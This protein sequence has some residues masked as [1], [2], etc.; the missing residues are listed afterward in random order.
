MDRIFDYCIVLFSGIVYVLLAKGF[1]KLPTDRQI[2]F[3][4]YSERK[5][6]ILLISAYALIAFSLTAIVWNL[7]FK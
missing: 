5:K 7:V 3:D 1:I 2:A 6:Q 4:Q